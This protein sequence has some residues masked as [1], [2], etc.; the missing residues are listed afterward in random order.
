MLL[1]GVDLLDSRNR[2]SVLNRLLLL[3]LIDLTKLESKFNWADN[4]PVS[5][6]DL[7]G[8]GGRLAKN[9]VQ[10]L[11]YRL[12]LDRQ[13]S[14]HLRYLLLLKQAALGGDLSDPLFAE[15][16]DV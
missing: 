3:L 6:L 1:I 15:R 7:L 4:G 13:A 16:T 8:G 5:P 12:L 2:S 9:R 11:L 10:L 14:F